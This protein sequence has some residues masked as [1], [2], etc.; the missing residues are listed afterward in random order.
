MPKNIPIDSLVPLPYNPR[1]IS[2]ESLERL[3]T[4]IMSHSDMVSKKDDG[5]R[6]VST[7]TVNKQ[8]NRIVGGNQR[9]TALKALG[10]AWIHQEDVTWIDVAP[11][12]AREK[13]LSIIL[14]SDKYQGE[15][16]SDRLEEI[17]N[18][19]HALDDDLFTELGMDSLGDFTLDDDEPING[20]EAKKRVDN[21]PSPQQ[22]EETDETEK[23]TPTPPKA[24][25]P[26][27]SNDQ[28]V[29]NKFTG[30]PGTN[31][32]D[33]TQFNVPRP[34]PPGPVPE[35]SAPIL[36]PVSY[37]VTADQRKHILDATAKARDAFKLET[38]AE[39]LAKICEEFCK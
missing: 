15:W 17:V 19:V 11:D 7:V 26:D 35:D 14:N 36:F 33:L 21:M 20:F 24:P 8:G 5:F 32:S 10:Q 31:H 38:S 25:K 12:S 16:D 1:T 27:T 39:A 4:S 34:P 2:K 6:L 9:V 13:A 3:K 18:E 37:A 22:Q 28:I 29:A 30:E 23:E